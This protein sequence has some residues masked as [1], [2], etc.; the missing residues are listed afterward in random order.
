MGE[1]LSVGGFRL[2]IYIYI[3]AA[4]A[5]V[6]AAAAAAAVVAATA[7]ISGSQTGRFSVAVLVQPDSQT[8]SQK[9]RRSLIVS[10]IA[11]HVVCFLEFRGRGG[12]KST[13]QAVFEQQP[14]EGD[15]S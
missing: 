12:S 7:V 6:A 11:S 5:A 1:G 9:P 4:A 8:A 2:Y 13:A 14:K 15:F 10:Q 3:A